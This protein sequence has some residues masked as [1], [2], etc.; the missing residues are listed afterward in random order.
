MNERTRPVRGRL[1][2]AVLVAAVAT[3]CVAVWWQGQASASTVPSSAAG[4]AALGLGVSAGPGDLA[5]RDLQGSLDLG[6]A[7]LAGA[8]TAK[9][10][11][12]GQLMALIVVV[13]VTVVAVW[14]IIRRHRRVLREEKDK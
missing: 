3:F 7:A 4:K 14:L 5:V 2:T 10:S 12:A 8:A 11:R 1:L 6:R 9:P 13:I